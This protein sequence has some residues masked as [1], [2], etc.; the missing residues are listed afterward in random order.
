MKMDKKIAIN[1]FIPSRGQPNEVSPNI[2]H[3]INDSRPTECHKLLE[4]TDR[5]LE[6]GQSEFAEGN[7]TI[8]TGTGGQSESIAGG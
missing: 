8:A 1:P 4:A 3:Q 5:L 6:D 7:P 2:G